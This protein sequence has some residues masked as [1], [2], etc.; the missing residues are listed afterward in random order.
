MSGAAAT[1][2][3]VAIVGGGYAGMAAAVELA[4]RDVAVT[5]FEAGRVLG[6]RARRVEL[7]GK[8]LDNGLHI[9]LGAYRE[10]LRLIDMVKEFDEEEGLLRLPLELTLH[11]HFAMKAPQLPAPLHLLGALLGARGLEWRDRIA[12]ARFMAWARRNRFRL[13]VDTTVEAL[14]AQKKQPA[15]VTRFLWRPLC[16]SALNTLPEEASAQVFLSVLRDGLDAQRSDSDML[17]PTM[18]FSALFPERAARFV[19]ERGGEVRLGTSIDTIRRTGEHFELA[20]GEYFTHAIL[21]LSP[22]RVCALLEPHPILLPVAK[23]IGEFRYQPIYSVYLQYAPQVQLPFAMGGLEAPYSQWLFDR[24][25][26]CGQHGL[27]GVVISASGAH[28]NLPHDAL[29]QVVHEELA[30][31]FRNLG[32]PL[33]HRVIAEKRATFACTPGLARPDNVTPVHRLFLAGDYTASDYPATIESAVRSG[34]RAASLV[35]QHD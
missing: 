17:L 25:R 23:M 6:G 14:L 2:I 12:A 32:D 33:S 5:V 24:G 31:N 22:H 21:A 26:L 9:L 16:I 11:P 1:P 28:Q 4:Q 35:K 15:A 18:D 29:A 13:G 30:A 20:R 7:D 8:S 3:R 10:T 27:I 19:R 34:V